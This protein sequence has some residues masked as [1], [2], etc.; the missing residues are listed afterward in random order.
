MIEGEVE[1]VEPLFMDVG[2]HRFWWEVKLKGRPE[3]FALHRKWFALFGDLNPGD[4]V[5]Y[6]I[7]KAKLGKDGSQRIDR[8]GWLLF[9]K[10]RRVE[11]EKPLEEEMM[12]LVEEGA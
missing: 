1:K 2:G 12:K 8:K 11:E 5:R 10:L 4:R 3:S 7:S 6:V 9:E